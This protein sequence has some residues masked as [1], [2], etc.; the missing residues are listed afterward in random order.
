L[1]EIIVEPEL[2][3]RDGVVER[4]LAGVVTIEVASS[5]AVSERQNQVVL[6]TG[7]VRAGQKD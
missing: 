7:R 3:D 1:V 4:V 6:H 2:V 5:R